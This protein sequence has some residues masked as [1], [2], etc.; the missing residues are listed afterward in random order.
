MIFFSWI[1]KG[2]R[3]L[4]EDSCEG[5]IALLCNSTEIMEKMRGDL[6]KKRNNDPKHKF[7]RMCL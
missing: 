2:P 4:L 3:E 5:R 6:K 7:V 1:W